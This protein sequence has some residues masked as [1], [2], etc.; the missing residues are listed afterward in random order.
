MAI[1]LGISGAAITVL[2]AGWGATRSHYRPYN[3][4]QDPWL[5]GFR[6]RYHVAQAQNNQFVQQASA[7]RRNDLRGS[8]HRVFSP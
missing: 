2:N 3:F 5:L 8:V 6:K 4:D 1:A 7:L